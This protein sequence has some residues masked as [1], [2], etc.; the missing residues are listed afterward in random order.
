M[1]G[2]TE[3]EELQMALAAS[4]E[5]RKTT[6][7]VPPEPAAS[8]PNAVRIQCRLPNGGRVVRR[9][10]STDPVLVVYAFCQERAGQPVELKFGFP[11]KDLGSCKEQTIGETGLA[12]ESV[13]AR[14][15]WE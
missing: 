12:G 2:L 4:L 7:K 10:L 13:Q 5:Q 11:P 14:F 6:V 8:T 15:A 9:F 1:E 3:D